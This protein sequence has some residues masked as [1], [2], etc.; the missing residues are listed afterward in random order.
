MR[1][2]G[3]PRPD[4]QIREHV[5]KCARQHLL[6]LGGEANQGI[7]LQLADDVPDDGQKWPRLVGDDKHACTAIVGMWKPL[8]PA[9]GFQ[10]VEHAAQR[11]RIERN[12]PRER[13][14]GDP[15]VLRQSEQRPA[16]RQVKL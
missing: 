12:Q 15:L 4:E 11:H 16:V 2:R 14:L 3:R 6:L 5:F 10:V 13:A 1:H 9:T 8:A 7:A